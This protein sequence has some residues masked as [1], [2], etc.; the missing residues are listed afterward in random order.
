MTDQLTHGPVDDLESALVDLASNIAFPPTPD[1]AAS[2]RRRL[3]T[4]AVVTE[5]P[6]RLRR[7]MRRA[8]LIAAALVLLVVGAA[9]GF[10][11]GLDLLVVQLGSLPSDRSATPSAG[12]PDPAAPG[13]GLRL[14]DARSLEEVRREAAFEVLLPAD[15]GTPDAV[16]V[17]GPSLRDQVALLY[18]PRPGLPAS[19]S[20]EGAALLIT[21]NRGTPDPGLAQKL[22]DAGTA[23][24]EPVTVD[25]V[26][27]RWISGQPHMFWYLS[28]EGDVIEDGRRLVGDTLIW[29]RDGVLYRIEGAI[30]MWR[31]VQIAESME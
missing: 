2:L 18:Q 31:A 17:G 4:R 10:G 30:R 22:V 28:P 29:E 26:P 3:Q 25:G 13:A 19:P 16:Y 12:A 14:G 7:S 11:W 5:P 6:H 27:G 24:V 15:L 21:Q 9:V 8:L 23:T 20:L 1:V